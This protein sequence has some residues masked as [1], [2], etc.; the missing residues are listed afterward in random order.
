MALGL[1]LIVGFAGLLD[2][3]YVAFYALGALTSG[4]FMSGFFVNASGG[5]GFSLLVGEPASTPARDPLQLPLGADHRR[6]HHR[7]SPGW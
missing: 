7:R 5:E 3:G 1:N 2:L 6:D 4:W